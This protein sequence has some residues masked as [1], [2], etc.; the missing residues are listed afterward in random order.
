MNMVWY[1]LSTDSLSDAIFAIMLLDHYLI[2]PL[3]SNSV[4]SDLYYGSKKHTHYS[5]IVRLYL[6]GGLWVCMAYESGGNSI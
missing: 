1:E 2:T 4:L 3:P 6:I 5:R